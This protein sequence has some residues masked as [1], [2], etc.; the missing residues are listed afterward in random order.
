MTKPTRRR[1]LLT[2]ISM[3]YSVHVGI[4]QSIE[5]YENKLKKSISDDTF[6]MKLVNYSGVSV[7]TV[8][9]VKLTV[10]SLT[11]SPSNTPT[12]I[13]YKSGTNK[14]LILR[15]QVSGRGIFRNHVFSKKKNS[16]FLTSFFFNIFLKKFKNVIFNI[17][18]N[19][20]FNIILKCYFPY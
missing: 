12:I 20:V 19:I 13:L 16:M 17:I 11:R 6:R 1:K 14:K 9:D 10:V 3:S 4:D 2:D 5:I 18:F 8:Y 7:S 15:L